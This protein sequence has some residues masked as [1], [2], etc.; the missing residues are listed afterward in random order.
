MINNLNLKFRIATSEKLF[1]NTQVISQFNTKI[2]QKN[3][4]VIENILSRIE[5][6]ELIEFVYDFAIDRFENFD[7][8]VSTNF[9]FQYFVR[10][11]IYVTWQNEQ[12]V[13]I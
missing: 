1:N 13:L 2:Q 7:N 4:N 6:S 10:L 11:K 9:K 3:N 12:R 8:D 5:S